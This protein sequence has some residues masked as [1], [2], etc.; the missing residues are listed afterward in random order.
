MTDQASGI[1]GRRL[2]RG[3]GSLA[4]AAVVLLILAG[5]A[6]VMI[7]SAPLWRWA[8]GTPVEENVL[9][10]PEA[11]EALPDRRFPALPNG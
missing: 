7:S 3:I 4:A 10:D 9:G 5:V 6:A 8:Q 2:A 1:V 11:A